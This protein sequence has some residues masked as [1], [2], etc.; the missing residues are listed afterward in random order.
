[1]TAL[2]KNILAIFLGLALAIVALEIMLRVFQPAEYRVRGNKITLI[3]DKAYTFY[4]SKIDK[5]DKIIHVKRNHLGFRGEPLPRNFAHTLTILTVGGSTTECIHI[6]DGKTWPD[7]LAN[8]LKREFKPFWLN[9]AGIDGHSTFGH[10]VL[11]EDYIIRLKPKIVLV[12]AGANDQSIKDYNPLDRKSLTKPTASAWG[13]FVNTLAWYSEVVNYAV[14]LNRYRKA[15]R[16]GLVHHNIDF[17][18]LKTLQVDDHRLKALLA[19]HKEHYLIPYGQRL[20]QLIDMARQHAIEPVFITQ[21]TIYGDVI[22]PVTGT[23][24]GQVDVGPFN[25]KTSWEILKLYNGVMRQV[26]AQHQVL[27]ID[28]AAVLPKTSRYFYDSYHFTN[29]G[30]QAVAEIIFRHLAPFLAQN[31]PRYASKVHPPENSGFIGRAEDQVL[32]G[33]GA[34]E[35]SPAGRHAKESGP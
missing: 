24:L 16:G 17:G 21:P 7:L 9:N 27:L 3:H 29:D 13:R 26:A 35:I 25:G 4:N 23:D 34:R 1:M 32:K 14:N 30:C 8:N 18:K 28:L 10:L 6:S 20:Q 22:D 19:Q 31:F 11:M 33:P 5:L 12:L 15:F 2:G